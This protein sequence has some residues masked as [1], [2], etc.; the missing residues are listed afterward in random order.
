MFSASVSTMS[1]FRASS[2]DFSSLADSEDSVS[3]SS[4]TPSA[5]S[6]TSRSSFIIFLRAARSSGT[7]LR[8]D[9]SRQSFTS[10][11]RRAH[12]CDD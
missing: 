10:C 8:S 1:F 5:S 12:S 7:V 9:A 3:S 6:K 11:K 2:S 4:S